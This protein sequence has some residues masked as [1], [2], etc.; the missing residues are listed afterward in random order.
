MARGRSL[1]VRSFRVEAFA[2][3]RQIASLVC[4]VKRSGNMLVGLEQ[5]RH[6]ILVRQFRP[7]K[8]IMTATMFMVLVKKEFIEN[9]LLK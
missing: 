7:N 4:Q 1:F 2:E 6:F 5:K 3:S 8:P 9:R